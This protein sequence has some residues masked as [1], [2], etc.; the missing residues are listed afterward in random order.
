MSDQDAAVVLLSAALIEIRYLSRHARRGTDGVSPADDLQHIW[1]LSDL[2]HNLPGV[3]RLSVWPPSRKNGTLSSRQGAMRER[4]M[5]WTWNTA[6]PEGR[7]WIIGQLDDADCPWTP[8][9]PLPNAS[10][11]PP[12]CRRPRPT[13][14]ARP[15]RLGVASA[16]AEHGCRNQRQSGLSDGVHGRSPASHPSRAHATARAPVRLVVASGA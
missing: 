12:N 8:P 1:F 9:P 15:G 5:S 10:K 2:C 7:A 3:T 11:G 4:P 6:G 14:R 13:W 16:A